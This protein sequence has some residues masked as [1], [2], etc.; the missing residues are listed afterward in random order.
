M[1]T[2]SLSDALD[3]FRKYPTQKWLIWAGAGVSLDK[4]T[5]LPS[6]PEFVSFTVRKICGQQVRDNLFD[7]WGKVNQAAATPIDATPLGDAPR[8]ES[9]LSEIAG[10]QSVK[11]DQDFQFFDGFSCFTGAPINDNHRLLA[12]L[13]KNGAS[14]VTTNFDI[15]IEKAFKRIVPGVQFDETLEEDIYY[16]TPR[17]TGSGTIIYIHGI[18]T[19]V[20]SLGITIERVKRGL[21]GS[22]AAKLD[23]MFSRGKTV[24]FVG[25]S[26]SDAF[27]VNP[28]LQE[29]AP[30]SF[31]YSFA[32]FIQHD[33]G[34][35]P[36]SHVPS[37]LKAFNDS[38][39]AIAKTSVFLSELVSLTGD[40]CSL[41]NLPPDVKCNFDW[42]SAFL[43][44]ADMRGASAAGPLTTLKI[45]NSMGFGYRAIDRKAFKKAELFKHYYEVKQSGQALSL[46]SRFERNF[47]K[48]KQY[49]KDAN[50][51][52]S[53]WAEIY[54]ARGQHKEALKHAIPLDQLWATAQ[55]GNEIGWNEYACMSIHCYEIVKR[56]LGFR[57]K[58]TVAERKHI[59]RLLE[60]VESLST[61]SFNKVGFINQLAVAMRKQIILR[62]LLEGV[63]N[64][65]VADQAFWIY[66]QGSSVSGLCGIHK[67]L[68]IANLFIAKYHEEF[69]KILPAYEY[70]KKAARIAKVGKRA[71]EIR[72]SKRVRNRILLYKIL[73]Y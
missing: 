27:D 13:L 58:V 29:K 63:Y 2:S 45:A 55:T 49:T 22:L 34:G 43:S 71:R 28:Y 70:A 57:K 62:A 15:C 30:N 61:R 8:L 53:T 24:G 16:R 6:A 44:D 35:Q 19:R 41:A 60:V 21:P 31:P 20:N 65:N 11:R 5:C 66:S 52:G 40:S 67:D 1:A 18:A 9:L 69:D 10:V 51:Q 68:A 64:Q 7:L 4:H 72:S 26:A 50:F 59:E 42:S 38:K 33:G 56:F 14:I 12:T 48:D 46:Y 3:L 47:R 54:A 36:P 32:V 39:T 37:L 17:L 25:Y 23:D 73:H